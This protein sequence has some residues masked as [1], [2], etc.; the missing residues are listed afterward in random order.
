[1]PHSVTRTCNSGEL[2]SEAASGSDPSM[3]QTVAQK[4]DS[5]QVWM[6]WMDDNFEIGRAE[7]ADRLVGV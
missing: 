6:V 3:I 7:A 1:M 2:C 4:D 5:G